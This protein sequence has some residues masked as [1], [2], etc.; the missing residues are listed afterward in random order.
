MGRVDL[1]ACLAQG[2]SEEVC[3]LGTRK[4]ALRAIMAHG[5]P[6]TLSGGT[7]SR[8][9]DPVLLDLAVEGAQAD[10][11]ELR[12]QGLVPRR[13]DEGG[14]DGVPLHLAEGAGGG[15]RDRFGGRRW[16]VRPGYLGG[17]VAGADR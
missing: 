1:E 6:P 13:L 12:R 17:E 15:Q 5:G 16:E 8:L 7:P 4:K 14:A 2:G 10:A 9:I 3:H 11:E